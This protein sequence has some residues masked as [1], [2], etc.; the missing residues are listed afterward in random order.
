MASAA[1][2]GL[3]A[4]QESLVVQATGKQAES[5]KASEPRWSLPK[6]SRDTEKKVF[7]SKKHPQDTLGRDSPGPVYIPRRQR[8][9][10]SWGFGTAAARPPAAPQ[11]YPETSNNLLGTLPDGQVFKYG[12]K[13]AT[14]GN[15]PR[16]GAGIN[17]PDFD[18]FEPGKISPGPQ[19]Y[20]PPAD[21]TYCH[22]LSWAKGADNIPP[23]YSIR[24]KT[25]IKELESQTPP[26]VGPGVYPCQEA[27]QPQASSEKPSKP[28]WSF[29]KTERFPQ[30]LVHGDAGRLWDGEGIRKIQF[31]RSFSQPPCY[32]FGTSTRQHRKKVA[33]IILPQD[34]G[35]AEDLGSNKQEHPTLAPRKEVLRFT[36]CPAGKN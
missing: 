35:P 21:S 22:R 16:F 7:I 5:L 15:C 36:D 10:P 8:S 12:Q 2:A 18:G 26:K 20:S 14:I 34:L 17:Q 31:Q 4:A 1:L 30:P 3:E 23:R 33:P 6:A 25:K 28:R 24:I 11:K 29:S 27:C 13:T 19:R 9:L 32:S